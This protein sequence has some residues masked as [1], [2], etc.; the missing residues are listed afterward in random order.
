[1]LKIRLIKCSCSDAYPTSAQKLGKHPLYFKGHRRKLAL[2]LQQALVNTT[3]ASPG[4]IRNTKPSNSICLSLENTI[5]ERIL[6][7]NI[8][9]GIVALVAAGD[10]LD[11]EQDPILDKHCVHTS[12]LTLLI[13]IWRARK[14]PP[15][16]LP[17]QRKKFARR[18]P[19]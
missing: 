11:D 18:Q 3:V 9:K 17:S 2:E 19:G 7:L 8:R 16:H 12:T 4:T 14:M 15:S 6:G 5:E 10:L 13:N 1:M